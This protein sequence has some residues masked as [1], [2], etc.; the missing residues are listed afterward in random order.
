MNA[1]PSSTFFSAPPEWGWLIALY[2]FF[3]GLA[4]GCYFIAVLI[5]LFG[6]PE[7]RALARLGYYIAL[8][9]LVISAILLTLDL[10]RPLRFWHM[11]LQSNTYRI[12]LKPWSPMSV[13][14]WAL[15]V[16][17]IFSLLSFL[18]ALA[19]DGRWQKPE[20]RRLRPPGALGSVIAT[21]GGLF[22]FFVSGY[23]GVLL[24]VTNR[25]IWSDTSLLGM[26]FVVSAASISAASMILLAQKSDRTTPGIY[27]LHRLDMWV[28]A[29][30][31]V[32]LIAVMFSLG[33]VF[34]V[35]LSAWGALLFVGVIFIGMLIPWALYF[36]K[37]WLGE[38]NL[39]I[40]AAL[41]VVGGLILRLV[42]VFSAQRV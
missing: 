23:T 31:F 40:G 27:S 42:I 26:L 4:G 33:P 36:R 28:V 5:D 41:V 15:L 22:G 12:M 16:F 34:R 13:G 25:P 24:G 6:R 8:P 14:S 32:V 11:L 10:G 3:G 9:C 37:E 1:F 29:L 30:E 35:W 17:G 18:G 21:I 20:A 19:E 39:I 2:F 38:R 7:D